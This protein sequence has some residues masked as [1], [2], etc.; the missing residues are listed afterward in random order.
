MAR[1]ATVLV[2]AFIAAAPSLACG[3]YGATFPMITAEDVSQGLVAEAWGKVVYVSDGITTKTV[4]VETTGITSMEFN[5]K[6][7]LVVHAVD[8]ETTRQ[9]TYSW[10]N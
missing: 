2:L 8:G 10:P 1:F 3:P 6:G 4:D 7:T 9:I 5:K